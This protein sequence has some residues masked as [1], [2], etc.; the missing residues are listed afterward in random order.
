M[1]LLKIKQQG[2]MLYVSIPVRAKLGWVKGDE[3]E[4]FKTITEEKEM[5]V[6]D[7]RGNTITN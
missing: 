5:V 7:V 6:Q 4:C 2:K 3:I 1:V